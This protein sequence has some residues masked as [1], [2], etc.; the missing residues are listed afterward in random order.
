MN[1]VNVNREDMRKFFV[2]KLSEGGFAPEGV[3]YRW[4]PN[5]IE[6][7]F[8]E[9]KSLY[10]DP[11]LSYPSPSLY[12][13][14]VFCIYSGAAFTEVLQF[15]AASYDYFHCSLYEALYGT[16]YKLTNYIK[17][18]R[19]CTFPEEIENDF[20]DNA[21]NLYE[22]LYKI[23]EEYFS[24]IGVPDLPFIRNYD[25]SLSEGFFVIINSVQVFKDLDSI[26]ANLYNVVRALRTG[27]RA[28]PGISKDPILSFQLCN[29][30][31]YHANDLGKNLFFDISQRNMRHTHGNI[32]LCPY[33]GSRSISTYIDGTA[34]CK[35][36]GRFF[37]YW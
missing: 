13:L 29:T 35:H 15:T 16:F 27:E 23:V 26:G 37:R 33:C 30:I 2:N 12:E 24:S 19:T 18:Q 34:E 21:I 1:Q 25:G 14:M 5:A 32:G 11:D 9:N 28:W 4:W 22:Y 20:T 6:N 36:C 7:I 8:T 10:L 31:R 3:D 17:N